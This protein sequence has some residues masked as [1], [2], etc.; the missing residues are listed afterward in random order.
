MFPG[1]STPRSPCNHP[2]TAAACKPTCYPVELRLGE[3]VVEGSSRGLPR[4]RGGSD[5]VLQEPVNV[6]CAPLGG[7][8]VS[9]GGGI[10][11]LVLSALQ[12]RA[13]LFRVETFTEPI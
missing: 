1:P 9:L 12:A 5:P 8:F 13:L 11:L 2:P 3:E 6:F 7:V 4:P 10:G